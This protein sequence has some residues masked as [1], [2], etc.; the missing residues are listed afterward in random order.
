DVL[1]MTLASIMLGSIV[2][3]SQVF[4]RSFLYGSSSRRYRS[5]S[6]NGGSGIFFI[7]AI[8]FSILAPIIARIFY[9]SLSRKREY[10]ADACAVR[11]T[12]YPKGLADA[13]EKISK[14]DISLARANSITAPMYIDSPLKKKHKKVN[15]SSGVNYLDYQKSFNALRGIDTVLIPQSGLAN[16]EQIRPKAVNLAEES[17]SSR[18]AHRETG[19]IMRAINHYAFLICAC[20]LK[21]KVPQGFDKPKLACPRCNKEHIVPVS[22]L[23]KAATILASV[24]L[25]EKES[26]K[27]ISRDNKIAVYKRK[28]KDWETFSCECGQSF[29]LSPAFSASE[30]FCHNCGKKIEI[31]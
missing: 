9:F 1:Y 23:S 24:N 27:A 12:R 8:V 15:L 20:G 19:D 7:V 6:S 26:P 17:K 30:I 18:L 11:L 10:L 21:I 13:L 4:F 25:K 14:N 5:S 28:S 16:K 22:N 31:V 2:L 3:I 29:Q